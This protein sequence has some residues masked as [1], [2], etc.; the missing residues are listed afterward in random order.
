[1]VDGRLELPR[2]AADRR[3]HRAGGVSRLADHE[4][5]A[6]YYEAA[7]RFLHSHRFASD[8]QRRIWELHAQAVSVKRIESHLRREGRRG[9]VKHEV[10]TVIATLRAKMLNPSRRGRPP[11]PG[12]CHAGSQ[13]FSFRMQDGVWEALCYLETKWRLS[14]QEVIRRL[15]FEAGRAS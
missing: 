2:D 13:T 10:Q 3:S 11:R 9:R 7:G 15:L 5:I 1:M 8:V 14:K 4:A 12:G 6:F